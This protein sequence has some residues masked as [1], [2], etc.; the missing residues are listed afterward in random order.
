MSLR[1]TALDK[2]VT[3]PLPPPQIEILRKQA[4]LDTDDFFKVAFG[5]HHPLRKKIFDM[6]LKNKQVFKHPHIED[7]DRET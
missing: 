3:T 7:V 2:Q 6:V 5:P 1:I 4:T